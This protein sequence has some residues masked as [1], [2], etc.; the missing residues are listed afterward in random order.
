MKLRKCQTLLY[1]SIALIAF[2]AGVLPVRAAPHP[3]IIVSAMMA[4]ASRGAPIP[5]RL[6]L[7]SQEFA[8]SLLPSVKSRV[9]GLVYVGES[10]RGHKL[11]IGADAV[12]TLAVHGTLR[13]PSGVLVPTHGLTQRKGNINLVVGG[14]VDQGRNFFT[15]NLAT[16]NQRA[17]EE[18]SAIL[19]RELNDIGLRFSEVI[20]EG[21]SFYLRGLAD[22]YFVFTRF[23]LNQIGSDAALLERILTIYNQAERVPGSGIL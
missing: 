18:L 12:E 14:K 16:L 8:S 17:I 4:R 15:P 3:S 1:S 19:E 13:L 20:V 9:D 23:T 2:I 10:I 5:E 22:E 7:E 6:I 21:E 11:L